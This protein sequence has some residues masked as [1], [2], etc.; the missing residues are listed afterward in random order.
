MF[1]IN[2]LL[3]AVRVIIFI[4]VVCSFFLWFDLMSDW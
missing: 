2:K 1:E 3:Q 4:F